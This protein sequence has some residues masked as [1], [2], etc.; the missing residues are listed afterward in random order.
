MIT[1][2]RTATGPVSDRYGKPNLLH[3]LAQRI[4]GAVLLGSVVCSPAVLF[5]QTEEIGEESA[6]KGVIFNKEFS[7]GGGLHTNGFNL[8]LQFAKIPKYYL[9]RFWQI[10]F[11][12]IKH[13]KEFKQSYDRLPVWTVNS[14]KSFVFG[15]QNNFYVFKLGYGEKR[16]FTDK[17]RKKGLAIGVNYLGGVSLGL[18]K[19]YYLDL[20]YPVNRPEQF[21]LRSE[22]YS[23]ENAVY[24][25]NPN[26]I[27][28]ASGIGMG[29]DG[30]RPLP[31]GFAK[32]GLV[33]DW[34]AFDEM[35]K[36]LEVGVMVDVYYKKVP[37][38]VTQHN[39]PFFVNL[40]VNAHL[41][42]RY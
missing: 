22:P 11:A 10:E 14:P 7:I 40:Y 31:G 26:V 33:F 8:N 39:Y 15:K 16:Y 17:G 34:G 5:S 12:E 36:A 2:N 38:M 6:P 32:A 24:F 3:Y 18:L 19:P 4:W 9:T 23:E 41:G 29:W 25:L 28:G 13:P 1:S 35:L 42:K 37:L 20:V 30:I 27:Y 21:E